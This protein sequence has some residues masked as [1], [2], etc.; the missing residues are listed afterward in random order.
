MTPKI[1]FYYP[2][3][4]NV[5]ASWMSIF[6]LLVYVNGAIAFPML[7]IKNEPVMSNFRSGVTNLE[8]EKDFFEIQGVETPATNAIPG[9]PDQPEVQGFTPIGL[10]DMV[11]PFTGDFSYNLPLMDVDGYPLNISY[12]AGITMEQE[13]SWVGLGWNLNPGVLNRN[14]RGLPDDFNGDKGDQVYKE[15]NQK[16]NLTKEYKIGL[17]YE[18]FGFDAAKAGTAKKW[19]DSVSGSINVA[20]SFSLR[21]NNQNGVSAGLNLGLDFN[22][23]NPAKTLRLDGGL[24]LSGNSASGA[25]IDPHVSFSLS[26]EKR[27]TSLSLSTPINSLQGLETRVTAQSTRSQSSNEDKY[28]SHSSGTSF[29]FG[30]VATYSPKI[31][32]PTG[33]SAISFS[34][35]LGLDV[36]GA[37]ASIH[38][39]RSIS[40]IW[41]KAKIVSVPAFGY[42]N[43]SA[44]RAN[45]EAL[46]DFNRENDGI[47]TKNVPALPIPVFTNDIFSATGHGIGGSYKAYRSE[48]G[49]NYDPFQRTSSSNISLDN[50]YNLGSIQKNGLDVNVSVAVNK[51]GFMEDELNYAANRFGYN[52]DQ[53]RFRESNEQA[54]D[55]KLSNLNNLGGDKPVRFQYNYSGFSSTLVGPNGQQYFNYAQDEITE[56]VRNQVMT[57]LTI[58]ELKNGIGIQPLHANSYA[59]GRT[60][61]DHH[62]GQYTVLNTEGTR[63]VYGI[64]AFSH[65]QRSATFAVDYQGILTKKDALISYSN[66]Q[67]SV[68][69]NSGRDNFYQCE[70]TPAY[71]HSYLLSCV[72]NADY[73]DSDNIKGP[74]KGD[75]G[76]YVQFSYKKID[77][78]KWRSPICATSNTANWD[79]GLA[80]DQLDDKANLVSGEKEVWYIT[81]VRTKNHIAIFHTSPRMD[82][83]SVEENGS[84]SVNTASMHRLDSISLYS[85]PDYEQ[86]GLNGTLIKRVHFV[87]DYSLCQGY[88]LNHDQSTQGGKLT[89]KKVYFTYANS[90]KGRYSYYS[91]NYANNPNFQHQAM[92]RWGNYRNQVTAIGSSNL[93]NPLTNAENPYLGRNKT[94][95]DQNVAAWSMSEIRLP[96]GGKIKVSYESDDYAYVQHRKSHEMVKIIGVS[97]NDDKITSEA[98]FGGVRSISSQNHKNPRLY[99]ELADKLDGSGKNT[100]I[101]SYRP[102]QNVV[103]FKTLT[104]IMDNLSSEDGFEY[105]TGFGEVAA[106]GITQHN[107][108]DVGYIDLK[109]VRLK[110]NGQREYHP[111]ALAG[112]QY[113]RINL[114]NFV[115][116]S[117]YPNVGINDDTP[118]LGDALLGMFDSFGGLILGPNNALYSKDIGNHIVMNK[119]WIRLQE[120]NSRKLGGGLRVKEI[121]ISDSWN[122]L[123][124]TE[125]AY[126]YGQTYHYNDENGKS[127]GVATYEPMAGNEENV[128]KMPLGY[129]YERKCG[130]DDKNF[131]LTPFGEQ[132]FP[133]PSV[134]YS[135]V[136][137]KDLPRN[138]ISRTATGKVVNEFYTARDFPTLTSRTTVDAPAAQKSKFFSYFFNVNTETMLA[139]QGFMV[140][141][142][143]MHGKPKGT[144]VFAENQNSPI[145]ST[146]YR[147]K[148]KKITLDGVEV[149]QLTND[150]TVVDQKGNQMTRSIGVNYD[151]V[152]DFRRSKSN[153]YSGSFDFNLNLV[154]FVP[155]AVGFPTV[156]MEST[157]FK[158]AVM[159]KLLE[160]FGIQDSIIAQDAGSIVTTKNLAYDAL[161]GAVLV[162]KTHTNFKDAIFNLTIPAHWYYDRMGQA[163]KNIETVKGNF[164]LVNGKTNAINSSTLVE[165]DEVV[166]YTSSNNVFYAWVEE[167][168]PLGCRIIS[169]D[170]SP[171]DGL[172]LVMKVI[173]SGRRNQASTPIATITSRQNPLDLLKFNQYKDVLQAGATEF[174]DQ[175]RTFC[176]CFIDEGF[177]AATTNPF[178]LGIKGTYRPIT[179]FVQL[180]GRNQ[181][182][183]QGN[184]NIRNDGFFTSFSPFYK[185]ENNKWQIDKQNW[186]FTS[187][188]EA[189]SP[190]GQALETRDALDRYTSSVFGYNQTLAKAVG[191]NTRYRQLGFDG[192]ED[193]NFTNCS[194]EHFKLTSNAHVVD[195]KSH[196]GKK[197]MLVTGNIDFVVP[198]ENPCDKIECKLNYT[199]VANHQ[200]GYSDFELVFNGGVAPYEVSYEV[201]QGDPKIS[202]N[203]LG[204]ISIRTASSCLMKLVVKDAKNCSQVFTLPFEVAQN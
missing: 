119:S 190:F 142:N 87:Y 52:S 201:L 115:P 1:P 174:S 69:N 65:F 81:E 203:Q 58:G 11:D 185:L 147:Y 24:G 39:S 175:W 164:T 146:F 107:G 15:I 59:Q 199:M 105:V 16:I 79:E 14:L 60:D 36:S 71:A 28:R 195:N 97:I 50:E 132:Y 104:R 123:S 91:F 167:S 99:F 178:V 191:V 135:K 129:D 194:D 54:V 70:V 139:S 89:L 109:A 144:A 202:Y 108:V 161:T 100:D 163:S 186:T 130:T 183:T 120:P 196:T 193:Y 180:S 173:R 44:A 66:Q 149:C 94:E 179:S 140:E 168:T 90:Q 148:H 67:N 126:E 48:I 162:S 114:N 2:S 122:E 137:V 84:L 124:S 118:N 62:I 47:F 3:D 145:S 21:Q 198:L 42:F 18:L 127:Y 53:I 37:D 101:E 25:T 75:L 76:G 57:G 80:I 182:F 13:A 7:Q 112:A 151:M 117:N 46:I 165:G 171:I 31:P 33:M 17:N 63:Y 150:V 64:A 41:T 110:D 56:P 20:A 23:K 35:K 78:H 49:Y 68:A 8:Y 27:R 189:F 134:G 204:N 22:L 153:S 88:P 93:N 125:S 111:M 176:N 155:I 143:D 200:S 6:L 103:F 158:S 51:S 152:A 72:L 181:S 9:G 159:M 86:N 98:L 113:S 192:F 95:V 55:E 32:I 77:N 187:S 10:S 43:L 169:K 160:R 45:K 136:V 172:I 131:S 92:D 38:A 61:L 141:L 133:S 4:T 26:G 177:Y 188:V 166:L 74:S 73:V 96:S 121:R 106:M 82:A 40:A 30:N 116:P 29:S 12:Q 83:P 156:S 170:G 128:M 5:E 184:S 85:L 154:T 102:F 157:D 138:G 34:S 197:S 19:L